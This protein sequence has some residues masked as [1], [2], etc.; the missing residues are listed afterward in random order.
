[1]QGCLCP[2]PPLL[3]PEVGG[4]HL[5]RVQS[6]VQAMTRLADDLGERDTIIVISP[7][8]PMYRDTFSVRTAATLQGDF[9]SF[10][11]PQVVQHY[12]TDQQLAQAILQR[13]AEA[14]LPLRGDD[15][16]WLDHGILVPLHFIRTRR[17]VC[18][19]IVAAYEV[20]HR[21][22]EV[23]REACQAA[24]R[25]VLLLAS[26]D[27]SHRL[28]RGAPAGYDER[29]RIFDRRVMELLAEGDLDSLMKL[30]RD[31][32][33]GAGECGLR[34]LI[35][36]AGYLGEDAARSPKVY[37]YEGPFGVGYLVAG[38]G[39]QDAAP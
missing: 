8:T 4:A 12:E 5:D 19:S 23:V 35:A 13:A 18:L 27:M 2:H 6:T 37:S 30:D 14:G 29:G 34:S 33:D 24:G 17:L 11:A 31:L 38:F 28:T 16:P 1:M 9:A 25:D 22:G 20:H 36:L 26:G 39:I 32:V 10:G 15:D 21:L 7:H 3:I